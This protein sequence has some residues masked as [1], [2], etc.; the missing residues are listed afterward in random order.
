MAKEQ[1]MTPTPNES[2]REVTA[3]RAI[4]PLMH[5]FHV[6]SEKTALALILQ[7]AK[8]I[9]GIDNLYNKV[10]ISKTELNGIM[11]LMRMINPRDT[12]ETLYAAQI[13]ASHMLGM[14]KLSEDHHLDHKLGLKLLRFSND[15]MRQLERKRI[16]GQQNI[17]VNYHYHG[18]GKAITQTIIPEKELNHA[19]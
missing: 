14:R 18:Q 11:S 10:V 7:A 4:V 6:D 5:A 16:G 15:A 13:V 17:T 9:Y 1:K 3:P 12:L 8:A 2:T 19:Y